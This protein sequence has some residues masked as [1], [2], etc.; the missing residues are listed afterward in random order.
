M[1]WRIYYPA[2]TFSDEDGS[3]DEAPSDDVQ[4]LV[5]WTNEGVNV[6][7]GVDAYSLPGHDG[8]KHGGKIGDRLYEQ[9][10][11]QARSDADDIHEAI[12][13]FRPRR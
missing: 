9:I 11:K 1:R 13:G 7:W 5:W 12:F 4:A 10:A 6:D 2:S 3:W 8:I